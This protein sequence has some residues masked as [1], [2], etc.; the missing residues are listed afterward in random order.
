MRATDLHH[1]SPL[2]VIFSFDSLLSLVYLTSATI[3]VRFRQG[4]TSHPELRNAILGL[5]AGTWLRGDLM[6]PD[7][8]GSITTKHLDLSDSK[9]IWLLQ[10]P[11]LHQSLFQ[12]TFN[13]SSF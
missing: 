11:F 8:E 9:A 1:L 12:Y 6:T 10:Q 5:N 2:S 4:A 13:Q 7:F 3:S